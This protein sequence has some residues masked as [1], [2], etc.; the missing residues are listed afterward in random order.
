MLSRF[1]PGVLVLTVAG[2][3][4]AACTSPAAAPES[5]PS[6]APASAPVTPLAS[7]SPSASPSSASSGGIFTGARQVWLR[8]A[9]GA[10]VLGVAGDDRVELSGSFG[11]RELFVLVPRSPGSETYSIRTG[12]IRE[13][14]EPA[15]LT[16]KE[17]GSDPLSLVATAC[18]A[19]SVTQ[20]FTF[21]SAGAGGGYHIEAA[22]GAYVWADERNGVYVE[23]LGDGPAATAFLPVDKGAV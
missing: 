10:D 1:R 2:G 4:L 22:G 20:R 23:E 14:G 18:D 17:N 21:R 13:G 7:A 5:T 8:P 11:D 9:K 6:L 19:E 15:C 12:K 3:A 16:V